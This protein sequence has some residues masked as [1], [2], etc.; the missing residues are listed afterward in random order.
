MTYEATVE[1]KFDATFTPTYGTSSW[2]SDDY[3][4]EEHYVITAPAAD[5]TAKQYFKLF[6]KFMLCVGMSPCSIRS[7]AMS[8]VF[9][10]YVNE[11]D[12]RKVC[13]E[14]ELTMDEDL[15]KKFEEWKKRDE[16]W[17]RLKKG[18]MGTVLQQEIDV[19]QYTDEQIQEMNLENGK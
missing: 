4:P 14:Y 6:E 16:E 9:N 7:G 10:D 2:T 17:A 18:P 19:T 15:D 8:L 12:Q 5:L 11:S 1:F 3:I 13:N